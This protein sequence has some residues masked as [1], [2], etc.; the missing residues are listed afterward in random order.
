MLGYCVKCNAKKEFVGATTEKKLSN[1]A[2][3]ILGKDDKGHK[4]SAIVSTK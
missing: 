2:K 4:M 1:G 3:M